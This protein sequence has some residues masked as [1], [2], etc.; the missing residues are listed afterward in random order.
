MII[1]VVVPAG[2]SVPVQSHVRSCLKFHTLD[3]IK[4]LQV[5][6]QVCLKRLE[7]LMQITYDPFSVAGTI[8]VGCGLSLGYTSGAVFTSQRF[9]AEQ[10]TLYEPV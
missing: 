10:L 6:H 5:G 9:E 3:T 1:L 2:R 8:L 7:L 4:I